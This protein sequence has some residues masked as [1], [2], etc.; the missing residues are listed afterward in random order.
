MAAGTTSSIAPEQPGGSPPRRQLHQLLRA[1]AAA[2]LGPL[3]ALRRL[4]AGPDENERRLWRMIEGLPAG[5]VHVEAGRLTLNRRAEEITGYRRDELPTVEAW[6]NALYPEHGETVRR[7]YYAALATGFH[8]PIVAPLRRKDGTSR[9]VE[10]AVYGDAEEAVWLLHDITDRLT[11]EQDLRASTGRLT[12]LVR[13][14]PDTVSIFDEDGGIFEVVQRDRTGRVAGRTGKSLADGLP[15]EVAAT[16]LAAIR[17]TIETGLSQSVEYRLEGAGEGC[18]WFEGRTAALPFD[19]G[20][21]PAVLLSVRDITPRHRVED[22]LRES[23][24]R[25]ALA[26]QGAHDVVWDWNLETGAVFFSDNWAARLG[27]D[28]G[29][30]PPGRAGW[31]AT[32]PPEDMSAVRAV[33][34]A[35]RLSREPTLEVSYRAVTKSGERRWWMARGQVLRRADGRAFRLAGTLSDITEAR[36]AEEEL[37]KAKERAERASD[38][39]SQFLANMSH[40]LRT[41]LNAIIGFSEILVRDGGAPLNRGRTMEYAGYIL[42]SGVHLLS[43]INDLLDMSR[44]EAGLYHLQEEEIDISQVF[45]HCLVTIGAK[46]EEG[47]VALVSRLDPDFAFLLWAE[48]RALQQVLLNILS[49]AIKFTTAGGRVTLACDR[50]SGGGIALTVT[51]TGI[52]I[53]REALGRVMEP[54]QQADM[55]ISRKFGGSGLGLAISRNL[56][57][58]HGGTLTLASTPGAGTIATVSLPQERVIEIRG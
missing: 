14:L 7:I 31:E 49:N 52:G 46:A 33:V 5:A 50:T 57:Q 10:F 11:A 23:E 13:T 54:F 47:G 3:A 1:I 37:L 41:P 15:A 43:L 25:Y 24:A 56:V 44:L 20:P 30:L 51:D 22:A 12:A 9:T 4:W 36:R 26:I 58:L 27:Y 17:R 55:T 32:M 34:E 16:L 19:F 18:S 39:K 21:R 48:R 6:F 45:D 28:E 35:C 29:E 53:E 2:V 8:Q 38:A 42:S 40:E